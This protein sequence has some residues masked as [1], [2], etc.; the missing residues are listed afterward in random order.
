MSTKRQLALIDALTG[1]LDAQN[2]VQAAWPAGSL[3][4]GEGDEFSDRDILALF[5]NG[6]AG[7]ASAALAISLAVADDL[8]PA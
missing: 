5:A 4:R 8:A 2:D 3:G 6:R 1:L 7:E